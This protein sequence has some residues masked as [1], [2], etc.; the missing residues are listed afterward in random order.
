MVVGIGQVPEN[1][2]NSLNSRLLRGR[3]IIGR[4]FSKGLT[5]LVYGIIIGAKNEER[6]GV[7]HCGLK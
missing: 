2:F 6:C 1:S 7:P 3:I 5:M 4:I